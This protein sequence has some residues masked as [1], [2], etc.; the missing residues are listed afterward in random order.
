[1]VFVGSTPEAVQVRASHQDTVLT[2]FRLPTHWQL[3]ATDCALEPVCHRQ[4]TVRDIQAEVTQA[5]ALHPLDQPPQRSQLTRGRCNNVNGRLPPMIRCTYTS[6]G[7]AAALQ[8][9]IRPCLQGF[10][11]TTSQLPKQLHQPLVDTL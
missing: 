2:C 8:S 1:M 4:L 11:I 9:P 10:K 3:S 5:G 7:V 6:S